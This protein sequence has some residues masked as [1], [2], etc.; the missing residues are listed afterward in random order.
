MERIHDGFELA[1]VDLSL[2]GPGDFFGTRQSGLPSLRIASYSD[3]DLLQ[4][5]RE[6]AIRILATDP[7]LLQPEHR[8]IARIVRGLLERVRDEVT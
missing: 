3:R 8:A 5:A 7:D 1:E 2:R 4:V 6:E